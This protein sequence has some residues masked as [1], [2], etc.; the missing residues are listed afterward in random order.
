MIVSLLFFTC[1]Y[2]V[3][4]EE[5]NYK[6]DII[7]MELIKAT[8]VHQNASFNCWLDAVKS[9]E[10]DSS[11]LPNPNMFN[12]DLTLG[13]SFCSVLGKN[14]QKALALGLTKCHMQESGRSS[15]PSICMDDG[16]SSNLNEVAI[17]RCISDLSQ[18]GF[19]TYTQFFVFTEQVSQNTACFTTCPTVTKSEL[20]PRI[21]N[22]KSHV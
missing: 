9:L 16:C 5:M 22:Y 3:L 13:Q 15:I 12:V 6:P 4:G 11:T 2:I 1:I 21:A 7:I 18:E 8:D 20:T 14:Q 10:L 17:R 19:I